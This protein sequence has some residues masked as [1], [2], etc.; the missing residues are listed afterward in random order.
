MR[1]RILMVMMMILLAG[2]TL[3]ADHA[4]PVTGGQSVIQ[5]NQSRTGDITFHVEVGR[6]EAMDVKTEAGNFT[7]LII[8]GYHTSKDVGN[9]ELPKMNRQA[10]TLTPF[11]ERSATASELIFRNVQKK[12]TYRPKL[13][14]KSIQVGLMRAAERIDQERSKS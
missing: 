11:F 8:P 13:P 9:P 1:F 7:R 6:I 12:L 4:I 3:A 14:Q 2:H 5:H 10:S